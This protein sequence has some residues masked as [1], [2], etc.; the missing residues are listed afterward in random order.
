MSAG[1][2]F[3]YDR[4]YQYMYT[5]AKTSINPY[6]PSQFEDSAFFP[7]SGDGRYM[8]D[9]RIMTADASCM[10]PVECMNNVNMASDSGADMILVTREVA[11]GLGYQVD[12]LS[13]DYNFLVQ[14][15]SG[16][17]T[18]FKEVTTW[19]QIGN[20]RPLQCPIGLAV[21]TDS[22]IENLFGN[23]G[24]VDSGEITATYSKQGVLY[25]EAMSNGASHLSVI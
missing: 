24:T 14:G 19:I 13:E 12:M 16:E 15:K 2:P 18:V 17:P 20:M 10:I 21:D 8:M 22:L 6:T 4:G 7:M 5:D 23:K 1:I 25:Q 9:V 3:R 11:D